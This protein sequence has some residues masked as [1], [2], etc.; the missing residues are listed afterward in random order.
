[1]SLWYSFWVLV[2]CSTSSIVYQK[3]AE[4]GISSLNPFAINYR[5]TVQYHLDSVFGHKSDIII[6]HDDI[7]NPI[8]SHRTNNYREIALPELVT[9]LERYQDRLKAIVFCPH[10]GSPNTFGFLKQTSIVTLHVILDLVSKRKQ[11]DLNLV[12]EYYRLHQKHHLELK[13]LT[14]VICY[15]NSLR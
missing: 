2:S 12:K 10:N 5:K 1:M 8:T 9:V 15:P 14:L 4:I 11:K 7:N 13:S 3:A 6:W